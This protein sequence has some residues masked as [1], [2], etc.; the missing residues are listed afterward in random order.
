MKHVNREHL[1]ELHCENENIVDKRHENEF[2]KWFSEKVS[3][4]F[5]ITSLITN[6]Y[7]VLGIVNTNYITCTGFAI[8]RIRVN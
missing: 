1:E 6:L 5:H 7:I 4:L 2:P 3:E 8:R